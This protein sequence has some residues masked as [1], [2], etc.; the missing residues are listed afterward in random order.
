MA[1]RKPE[2]EVGSYSH[3]EATRKNIPTAETERFMA[4]EEAAP[5]K[6]RWPRNPDLDPQLVW[7]G[8]DWQGDLEVPVVPVYIQE[9]IHPQAII[10]DLRRQ[11][12]A[13]AKEEAG[14]TPDLFADFNGLPDLEAKL[15]FYQ[16]DQHWSN[17]MI[18]GDSLLVMAS[19]AEKEGLK[20]KVQMIY[21]DPPYGIKFQFKLASQ[22]HRTKNTRR[23]DLSL[24]REPEVINAFRDTW[25]LMA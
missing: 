4:D 16:H 22:L 12:A 25:A 15:E 1:K 24:S 18:L 23:H 2:T 11:T 9:K 20:G 14:D 21:M 13:R 19:L 6:L 17:R 3:P 7:R 8:K 10:E 5:K